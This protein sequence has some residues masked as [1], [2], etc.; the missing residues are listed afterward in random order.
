MSRRSSRF[1]EALAI[2]TLSLAS[3]YAEAQ[4]CC[5]GGGAYA[6]ARLKIY[7]TAAIGV[8]LRGIDALGSFDGSG[9][10]FTGAAGDVE[11]GLE[12]D[13]VAAYRIN[14]AAQ[15]GLVI[16]FQETY[17]GAA[18]LSGFGG[19]LG[20]IGVNGRYEFTPTG[21]EKG[22]PGVSLNASITVPSGR[23][24][25]SARTP[26][27]VD[28]TGSGYWQG[29]LGTTLEKLF[30]RWLLAGTL[31]VSGVLPR[32]IGET[33]QVLGP[34][35]AGLLAGG[36]GFRNGAAVVGT[37]GCRGTTAAFV[38]GRSVPDAPVLSTIGVAIGWPINFEWRLQGAL[39]SDLPVLGRSHEVGLAL[40]ATL[41]R[42]F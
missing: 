36:Y 27:A 8:Q 20:D 31:S 4:S 22:L 21:G 17:R 30:G 6:P 37:I 25:E 41:L 2:V 26:L 29:S 7:E 14:E 28:S 5:A 1:I 19:G 39:S 38:N 13:L 11:L 10:Y 12:Q 42:T 24:P 34:Q 9:R 33:T 18:G 15:V 23:A 32:R 35:L 40:S 16:P 3:R